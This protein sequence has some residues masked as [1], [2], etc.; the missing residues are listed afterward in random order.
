MAE[1]DRPVRIEKVVV[2]GKRQRPQALPVV[3]QVARLVRKHGLK[4]AFDP[5][6]ARALGRKPASR[7]GMPSGDLYVVIGGDG[8]LLSVARA[9]T[10]RPR[11]I[12]GVNLGGLGFLSEIGP[13]EVEPAL[14]EVLRGRFAIERRMALEVTLMRGRRYAPLHR[15]LNDVVIN[16]SALARIVN[17][18]LTIDGEFVTVYRA[19]GLIVSTPTGSTAYSLSAGGPIIHPGMTAL[20]IAPICPHTLTM[21]PLVV[22]ESATVDVTLR[23][24][25]SEVYLTLDGQVGHPLRGGDRVRVRRSR[26]PVFMVRAG[27]TN[28]YEVL[29]RKL[30]WG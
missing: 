1:T 14:D 13:E 5:H 25:D 16:K 30:R 27:R 7:A 22:S 23:S 20:I 2:V 28:Y 8:T 10:A 15:V 12:L 26:Q 11:P 18:E 6:T 29:R 19:D 17:L 24:N 4:V 3:R 9:T 21:R